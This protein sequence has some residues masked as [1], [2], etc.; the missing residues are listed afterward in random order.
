MSTLTQKTTRVVEAQ[1]KL[2]DQ[3]K[4][5][6]NI[7]ALVKA[8]AQQSQELEAA[9]FEVL[10]N[11]LLDTAVGVQLDGLGDIIGV[12]RGGLSDA[13]YRVRLRAQILLNKSSGTI[14]EIV[15]IGEAL[16]ITNFELSEV[17]PAKIEIEVSDLLL[18]GAVIANT[19]SRAKAGGVGFYMTWFEDSN[20]FEFDT[21][22]QGFDQGKLGGAFSV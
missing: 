2:I 14:P 8:L 22:G 11:T 15:T 13:D 1:G 5:H 6:T 10:L 7:D 3:F 12:E 9:A 17:F 19:L 20:Y 21:V 4:N 18:N 16:T